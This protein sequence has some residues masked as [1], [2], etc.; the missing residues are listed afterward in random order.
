MTRSSGPGQCGSACGPIGV[1]TGGGAATWSRGTVPAK[2]AVMP[3][4]KTDP[5]LDVF[6]EIRRPGAHLEE[7]V[8]IEGEETREE[9]L[10][11]V[12]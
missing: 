11:L 4:A 6:L 2:E 8:V 1:D 12:A 3:D 5:Q 9:E 10:Q 7:D